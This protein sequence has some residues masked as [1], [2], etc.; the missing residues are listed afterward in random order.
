MFNSTKY[1]TWYYNLVLSRQD[2]DRDCFTETHHI[3]P[4][5]FG[6][7]NKKDNLVKLTPRE[8]Y[9]CHK[10]LLKMVDEPKKK[11]SMAYAFFRMK[12]SNNE[13][14]RIKSSSDYDRVRKSISYLVSGKNNS[15][16]G[17]GHFGK[18]NPMSK[19]ENR[20]SHRIGMLSRS[21]PDYT[22]ENNPFYGKNH[23]KETKQKLSEYAK[24]RTG[25][26]SN[27]WGKKHRRVICEF[28]N[29]EIA[30]PMYTRWHGENCKM[31][32]TN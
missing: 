31:Y 3:I 7:N 6:G 17:K 10:L 11:R 8:H 24:L 4:K 29:K 25:K 20:E 21:Q 16:Y 19:P 22:G 9:I 18:D 28:C 26:K 32:Q 14:K 23:T 27:N 30:F 5:C 12:Q 2:F 13:H 1:T 15:F